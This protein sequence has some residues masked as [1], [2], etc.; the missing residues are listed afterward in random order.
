[1]PD[2]LLHVDHLKCGGCA[3]TIRHRLEELAGVTGVWVDNE[4]GTVMV[5]HDGSTEH[6]EVTAVLKRLGYP[7]RGTG[8]VVELAKS[9][10]SCAIGRMRYED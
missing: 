4:A 7:E 5:A 6:D 9:Y 2:L 1:M 3:S 10:V 8:G